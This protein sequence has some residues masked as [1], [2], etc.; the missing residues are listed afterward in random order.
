MEIHPTLLT[1]LEMTLWLTNL[2][3]K[4][5]NIEIK[6]TWNL[7]AHSFQINKVKDRWCPRAWNEQYAIPFLT[8]IKTHM[9][10]EILSQQSQLVVLW[11]YLCPISCVMVWARVIPLSSLTLQL[12]SGWHIPPTCA[13]PSVLHGVFWRA[14]MSSLSY[15]KHTC[16][17]TINHIQ[18]VRS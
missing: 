13:T 5:Q 14:Q 7:R 1:L 10:S 18:S 6:W 12:R 11:T 16:H 4:I 2:W 15:M 3:F 9:R 8:F 17:G